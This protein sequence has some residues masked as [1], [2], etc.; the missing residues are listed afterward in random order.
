MSQS[1][2]AFREFAEQYPEIERE[3]YKKSN[4]IAVL[5]VKD[6]SELKNLCEK[7]DSKEIKFSKFKEPDLDNELTA[8]AIEPSK[9]ARKACSSIG[10]ALKECSL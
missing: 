6:E 10:L 5:S 1:L 9:S 3:W 8:V 2:H 4:Y 7:L